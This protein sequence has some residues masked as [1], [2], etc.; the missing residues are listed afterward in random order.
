M[1]ADNQRA[2]HADMISGE[3]ACGGPAE[4][5][6][7]RLRIRLVEFDRSELSFAPTARLLNLGPVAVV[8]HSGPPPQGCKT[9]QTPSRRRKAQR[10]PSRS[11]SREKTNRMR[12]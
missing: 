5:A 7:R 1:W 10:N 12:T 9:G 11:T 6:E 4:A 3:E 8:D 2:Q